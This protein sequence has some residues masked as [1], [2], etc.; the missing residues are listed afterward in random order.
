MIAIAHTDSGELFA[1]GDNMQGQLGLGDTE[2][3]TTPTL[4]TALSGKHVTAIACG[5]ESIAA[6]H[7]LHALLCTLSITLTA[8]R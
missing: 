7:G 1:W 5:A 2:R 4:I 8:T 6:L 3:R